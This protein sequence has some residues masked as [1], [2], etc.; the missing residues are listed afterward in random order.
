MSHVMK[1]VVN[2]VDYS[3]QQGEQEEKTDLQE[4]GD[5]AQCTDQ[6]REALLQSVYS[7]CGIMNE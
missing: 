5:E 3:E 7:W 6:Q 1:V 4:G 2:E